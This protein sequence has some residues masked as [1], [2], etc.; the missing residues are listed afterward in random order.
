MYGWHACINV[1]FPVELDLGKALPDTE[2]NGV[3]AELLPQTYVDY[4]YMP[5]EF[6]VLQLRDQCR[7]ECRANTYKSSKHFE[8]RGG[9]QETR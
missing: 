9:E 4:G 6:Y 1:I 7:I 3:S 8:W 5:V 2:S